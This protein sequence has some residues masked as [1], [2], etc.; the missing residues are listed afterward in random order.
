[1]YVVLIKKVD[2]YDVYIETVYIGETDPKDVIDG[3]KPELTPIKKKPKRV[4]TK[5]QIA[6]L[7]KEGF[8]KVDFVEIEKD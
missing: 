6:A 2:F 1:M 3:I 7:E 4:T 8:R 5:Q